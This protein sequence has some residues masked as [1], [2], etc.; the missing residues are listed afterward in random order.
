MPAVQI[1]V[2][3]LQA[4]M[5]LLPRALDRAAAWRAVSSKVEGWVATGTGPT[6]ED[7]AAQNDQIAQLAAERDAILA[8]RGGAQ[9]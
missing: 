3:V 1:A 5:T 7:F 6:G 9:P 2:Y 4:L 8:A